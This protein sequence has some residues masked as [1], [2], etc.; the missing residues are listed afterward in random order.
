MEISSSYDKQIA[1]R[2]NIR[3]ESPSINSCVLLC[4]GFGATSTMPPIQG[5][6]DLLAVNNMVVTFDF[7][8]KGIGV[9]SYT[10]CLHDLFTVLTF[11]AEKGIKDITLVGHSMGAAV[12]MIASCKYASIGIMK[13]LVLLA[14]PTDVRGFRERYHVPIFKSGDTQKEI[15]LKGISYTITKDF[16]ED[17]YSY[18][19]AHYLR[20]VRIPTL[21][22]HGSKDS[23]IR[24]SD[25]KNAYAMLFS[26]EPRLKKRKYY[27]E[28]KG[29][30]HRFLG[31][32]VQ[33]AISLE[34]EWLHNKKYSPL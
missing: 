23:I 20:S 1:I 32:K 9:P 25:E 16:I 5:L 27:K 15:K 11:L 10:E 8:G 30:G 2:T 21:I 34:I 4:H 18:S 24:I 31:K 17:I 12:C 14:M 22:I 13:K 28:I 19:F 33:K 26:T 7:I 29:A 6:Y 3:F